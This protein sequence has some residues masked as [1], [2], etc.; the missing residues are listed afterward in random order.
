MKRSITLLLAGI[1]VAG[2]GMVSRAQVD[3][4]EFPVGTTHMV[5]EVRAEDLSEPQTMELTVTVYGDDQYKVRMVTEAV[6][7]EDE[8][9]TGFGFIFGSASVSS[10][11][12]HDADYSSL[13]ALMDQR[14]RLQEGQEYALPGADFVEIVGVEIAGVWCLEG[15]IVDDD[16]PNVRMSV[17]FSLTNPVY[18]SPRIQVLEQRDGEWVETFAL[19]LVEYVF[20]ESGG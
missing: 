1:T 12:G 18:I 4:S 17:A 15:T 5:Y 8:L 14:Q 10:G 16:D 13:Q 2:L 6:G 9:A 7:N 3:L 19:E 20:D 11:S